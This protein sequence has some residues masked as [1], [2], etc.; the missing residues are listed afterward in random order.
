M[1]LI[2]MRRFLLLCLLFAISRMA[3]DGLDVFIN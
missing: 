1:I 3:R 2:N